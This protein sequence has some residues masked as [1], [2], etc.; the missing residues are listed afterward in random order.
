M[1]ICTPKHMPA[2]LPENTHNPLYNSFQNLCQLAL[3]EI[4]VQHIFFVKIS[5]FTKFTNIFFSFP[6]NQP[7]KT[8]VTGVTN[9]VYVGGCKVGAS[10]L[11]KGENALLHFAK[12]RG[13]YSYFID[14]DNN[15]IVLVTASMNGGIFGNLLYGKVEHILMGL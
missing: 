1:F 2:K 15:K 4:P 9:R 8:L 3:F 7:K 6:Y 14:N 11:C 10:G 13:E 12:S 5:C